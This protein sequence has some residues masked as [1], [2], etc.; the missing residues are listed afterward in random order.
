MITGPK[1]PFTNI[2]PGIE[3]QI[4]FISK[5]IEKAGKSSTSPIEATHEAEQE[6]AKLCEQLASGSLFWKASENWI[7]GAN[8]PG[9]KRCLRFF[10]GGLQG[11]CEKLA[12][13]A[14]NGYPGFKPFAQV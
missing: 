12:I 9:K 7:F 2:P 14:Q 1:G 6:Y 3:A 13:E 10:F 8:I 11:Y 5:A 4:E